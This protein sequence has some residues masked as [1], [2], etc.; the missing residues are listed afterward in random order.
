MGTV[1]FSSSVLIGC[2][3]CASASAARGTKAVPVPVTVA[4][5]E[6]SLVPCAEQVLS[7]AGA[8]KECIG[9]LTC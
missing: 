2:V 4:P 6:L 9:L 3:L 8:A 7:K 1:V 5:S